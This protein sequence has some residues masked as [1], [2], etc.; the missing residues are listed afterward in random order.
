MENKPIHFHIY[1]TSITR[2]LSFSNI[3]INKLITLRVESSSIIS[4][5]S[6][7]TDNIIINT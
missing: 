7:I 6:N 2:Q 5:D 1:S 4:I 3:E